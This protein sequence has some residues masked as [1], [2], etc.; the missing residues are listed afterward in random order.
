[1]KKVKILG[2]VSCL[3]LFV[4][5]SCD[6]SGKFALTIDQMEETRVQGTTMGALYSI[7]VVGNFYGGEQTLT[8]LADTTFNKISYPGP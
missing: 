8:E 6:D 4:I 7:Q 2:L 1:M 3:M 5:A